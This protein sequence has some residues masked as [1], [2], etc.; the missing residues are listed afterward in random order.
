MGN[1]PTNVRTHVRPAGQRVLDQTASP[2]PR[3]RASQSERRPAVVANK[4]AKK[5]LRFFERTAGRFKSWKENRK[6]T[7]FRR[8][9]GR[10]VS[11][12]TRG[13]AT[14]DFKKVY[15]GLKRLHN[16][17]QKLFN[18]D[19]KGWGLN[20]TN[21]I[22]DRLHSVVSKC[23]PYEKKDNDEKVEGNLMKFA[24]PRNGFVDQY[25]DS[26]TLFHR[27]LPG[28]KRA[29]LISQR[30]LDLR[31]ERIQTQDNKIKVSLQSMQD[32]LQERMHMRVQFISLKEKADT[33]SA[34]ASEMCDLG[35]CYRDDRGVDR[36][37]K[38]AA[39]LFQQAA[40]RGYDPAKVALEELAQ[41]MRSA[42]TGID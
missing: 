22:L 10:A 14:G 37:I 20:D 19:G 8:S 12:I 16:A 5:I 40:G 18:M 15:Q 4:F 36:N 35:V 1:A 28:L 32:R 9:D 39:S 33:G 27:M 3:F 26:K 13:L 2:E 30:Y 42:G 6:E 25:S 7:A 41:K 24:E 11:T 29:R 31:T 34:S 21:Y 38:E 23:V 17:E